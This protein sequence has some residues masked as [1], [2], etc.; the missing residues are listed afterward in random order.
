MTVDIKDTVSPMLAGLISQLEG[1]YTIRVD[2]GGE[3]T[4]GKI[5]WLK[6]G[7]RDFLKPTPQMAA[8]ATKLAAR[9]LDAE[10]RKAKAT[11]HVDMTKVMQAIGEGAWAH[12]L[13]RFAGGKRDVPM[14]S[15][16]KAWLKRKA[17]AGKP[18][19]IGHGLTGDLVKDLAS[20]TVTTRRT[21]R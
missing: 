7:G 4:A 12:V 15:L 21:G 17:A 16:T 13:I 20:A 5:E 1:D 2:V 19:L 18:S 10:V 11:G 9:V 8:E 3:E 14:K 6:D